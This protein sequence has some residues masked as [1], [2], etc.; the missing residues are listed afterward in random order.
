M[1][2]TTTKTVWQLIKEVDE[3][4]KILENLKERH[5]KELGEAEFALSKAQATLT[6]ARSEEP[7]QLFDFEP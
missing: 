5:A 2:D 4:Q 6:K 3:A 1:S 7:P